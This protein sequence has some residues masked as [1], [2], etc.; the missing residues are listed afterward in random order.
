MARKT[1]TIEY[2]ER[3]VEWAG[4]KLEFCRLSG[5]RPGNL[6]DY[7]QGR[8]SIAWKRLK[9]ATQQVFGEPPAFCPVVEGHDLF[10]D[11]VPKLSTLPNEAGLYA[12][13]DSSMRLIYFGKASSLNTEVKQT[14]GRHVAEVKPWS[15][16]KNLKFSHISAFLSAYTIARGDSTFRHDVEA[17]GLRLFVNNTFNKNS[18]SFKRKV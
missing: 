17:L 10:K 14:L 1:A 7:L 15:G 8:K 16:A 12:F 6:T 9:A 5:I 2:L 3:L 13:F 18:A 4:G 11:G